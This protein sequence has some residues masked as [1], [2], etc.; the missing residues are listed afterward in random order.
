VVAAKLA[1]AA[2]AGLAM[3]LV[4][5]A[6]VLAV[7][8]PWLRARG[9]EVALA[10]AGLWAR[11]A[12]LAVAVALHAVLGVGL[13][14]LLRNQVAALVVGL[15]WWSQGVERVLVGLLHQPGLERW[16]PLGAASALTAPGRGT[17]PMWA[18]GLVFAAYGLAMAALGGRLVVRRDLT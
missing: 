12:G 15:L 1:A 11:V 7:G 17:L 4:A 10:D 8:L 16:L 6:V 9:V 18:G 3:A 2:A 13:A 5:A 14:A